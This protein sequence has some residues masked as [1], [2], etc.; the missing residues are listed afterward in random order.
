MSVLDTLT[1]LKQFRY[2]AFRLKAG[3][4]PKED[5]GEIIHGQPVYLEGF[6]EEVEKMKFFD[7]W[8]NFGDTWDVYWI[9]WHPR[10]RQWLPS[11]YSPSR[12]IVQPIRLKKL[13]VNRKPQET[14]EEILWRIGYKEMPKGNVWMDDTDIKIAEKIG[15]P[16]TEDKLSTKQQG[17]GPKLNRKSRRAHEKKVEQIQ[18]NWKK[19]TAKAVKET[20]ERQAE[21]LKAKDDAS[22]SK[23]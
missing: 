11:F 4:Y 3:N 16:I 10:L 20:E 22:S 15:S 19:K 18:K 9:G 12:I 17:H 6:K 1:T 8:K 21:N 7:K 2:R 14:N 13:Q 5:N 23:L